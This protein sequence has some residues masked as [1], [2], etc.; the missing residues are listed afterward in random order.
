V[1]VMKQPGNSSTA[2]STR[3]GTNNVK[4]TPTHFCNN[5]SLQRKKI[6]YKST[7]FSLRN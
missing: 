4:S 6:Q 7:T 2:Y 5:I 1:L 3:L